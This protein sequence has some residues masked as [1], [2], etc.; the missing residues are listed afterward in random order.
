MA[1]YVTSPVTIARGSYLDLIGGSAVPAPGH[2]HEAPARTVTR[3]AR[4]VARISSRSLHR[5]QARLAERL[6]DLLGGAA[7]E[8]MRVLIR[9]VTLR[10]EITCARDPTSRYL[11]PTA[12]G[13]LR[14]LDSNPE[15]AWHARGQRQ[16]Q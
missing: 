1:N 15:G 14:H 7:V 10:S 13:Q 9:P 3:Q 5:V 2:G 8:R 12:T 11:C 16:C 4:E 6:L